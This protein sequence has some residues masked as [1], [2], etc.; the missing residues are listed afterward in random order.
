MGAEGVVV[1]GPYPSLHTLELFRSA[2]FAPRQRAGAPRLD[3]SSL[4]LP[5]AE[6][7]AANTIWLDHRMLLADAEDV[8]DIARAAARVHANADAVAV[9]RAAGALPTRVARA[10]RAPRR[11]A[12]AARS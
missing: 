9:A 3:Y 2:R 5:H 7:A 6:H 10:A 11:A 12:P 1:G 4:S 8:L